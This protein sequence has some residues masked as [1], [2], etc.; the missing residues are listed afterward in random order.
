VADSKDQRGIYFESPDVRRGVLIDERTLD[1]QVT[2]I[3]IV[4][5]LINRECL[6]QVGAFDESLIRYSD[7]DLLIRLSD[8]YDLSPL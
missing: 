5:A 4:S 7:L 3:G 8:R 6:A 1:Y 2:C